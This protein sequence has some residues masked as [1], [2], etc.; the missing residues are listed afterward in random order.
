[1]MKK[2]VPGI[3]A[4]L[5]L[6]VMPALAGT[7]KW[8]FNTDP[9]A[10]TAPLTLLGSGF[11]G[12]DWVP[13]DGASGGSND[14]YLSVTG[15]SGSQWAKIFFPDIDA[16][17]VVTAFT[18]ECKLR[19]GNGSSTPA[20]GFSINYARATDPTF[21]KDA[22]GNYQSGG[23][24]G[25]ANEPGSV[26]GSMGGLPEEGTITG[27][28]VGF[29]AYNSGSALWPADLNG[30]LNDVIGISVR[31][32][33]KVVVQVPLSTANGA[34]D[35]ATSL[36]TGPLNADGDSSNLS[37]LCWQPFKVQLTEDKHLSIWWKGKAVVDN[38]QV[39]FAPGAGR[40]VFGGRTGGSFQNQ[41]VDDITLTTIGA[42]KAQVSSAT[43]DAVSVTATID[44]S[45]DSS[46]DTSTV[47]MTVDG[48]AVT[49]LTV[50]KSGNNTTVKYTTSNYF[51]SGQK[52]AVV[53][54]CKDTRGVAITGTINAT[55]SAYAAIP[56]A[57]KSTAVDTSK[58]GFLFR[59]Y[60]TAET[61][62]NTLAWTEEQLIGLHGAN[63]ADLT[64]ASG[65]YLTYTSVINFNGDAPN[66]IGSFTSANGFTDVTF[67][68]YPGTTG[69]TGNASEEVLTYLHFPSAG[70]YQLAVNS[71]DG[72]R[73]SAGRAPGDVLGTVLGFYDGGRGASDTVFSVLVTEAGYYPIRLIWENGSGE[74]PD[75]G[76]NLEF[77]SV[78][79]GVKTL[80]NDTGA[81]AIKAYRASS[82]YGPYFTSVIPQ[83]GATGVPGNT[84][85]KA[86]IADG[87]VAV[88]AS[89]LKVKVNGV[90]VT[91][92]V[93]TA[94]GKT[95]IVLST[96]L[97]ASGSNYTVSVE[98]SD[99]SAT[100]AAYAADWQFTVAKYSV[101]SESV[102]TDV[103]T[104]DSTK[105]GLK[106]RVWQVDQPGTTSLANRTHRAEQE[107]A[108]VIGANV[109]DL[110][111]ATGGVFSSDVINWNQA[112]DSEE[113]GNFTS[114]STPSRPDAA[115]PGIPGTGSNPND[116]VAGEAITYIEF[117][118]A[119][120]Y[121]MG[122]FADDGFKVTATD[123][124]PVNNQALVISGAAS[125]AGSYAALSGPPA[126]SKQ[127]TAPVSGKLV[128]VD[129]AEGCS[130]FVNTNDMKGAIAIV[131]RG[132]CNFSTKIKGAKDA[133]AVA[134]II[135]NNRAL[136]NAEGVFPTSMGVGDVGYQ[137]LPAV[138]IS[139][140]DGDKIRTA[141]ASGLT[142]SIT[143]DTTPALGENDGDS[144]GAEATFSFIVP[145][146]GVYPF[147][148]V[149]FEGNGGAHVEWYSVTASGERILINDRANSNA[150]K[151]YK[152]RTATPV[153]TKPTLSYTRSGSDIVIT[154]T[155]VLQSSATVNG[156]YTDV[157]GATSPATVS[158]TSGSLFY[159]TRSN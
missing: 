54:S 138:M 29:D 65:G 11:G 22:D 86:E 158:T 98:F 36:Q 49:P 131:N 66:D 4:L 123:A 63:L 156:T 130:P 151:G 31:V 51:T 75:N 154:Y 67:P 52:L 34:C 78:K 100:P 139:K 109:A 93:T 157:S 46:V 129:P 85:I 80:I 28:A 57:Y 53:V 118:T 117:P 68:G 17:K 145:T 12:G 5:G 39:D 48:V 90:S 111:A 32:D 108:G 58:P 16:G 44:D 125:V 7:A 8:D 89:T 137:D 92:T 43:A 94:S 23:W 72:F 105:P 133:G 41:H 126:T 27:L 114:S 9:T 59:P 25:T 83:R 103:G 61:Q 150:L 2:S 127:F 64:G 144:T 15:P 141:M 88:D 19:I 24:S 149:W 155:G 143:P 45:G 37:D 152:A 18:F 128:E 26:E 121:T 60:Q 3:I 148:L 122:V 82:A 106:A 147:R 102:R 76:M 79:D 84:A 70:L 124:P 38:L 112:Y 96:G 146:A 69:S 116:S 81:N 30:T 97:L 6:A 120:Y 115:I 50:T 20:D 62:P 107:L 101:L 71:D 87:S 95:S 40:L 21:T 159:R 132:T 140:P 104:G 134:C 13:T 73:V 35:D 142:A 91:P 99:K 153:P 1:M 119:G 136:D 135:V 47:T 10:G 55:V 113:L 42:E 14:G 110:T 56:T 74:L 33:N 77:F